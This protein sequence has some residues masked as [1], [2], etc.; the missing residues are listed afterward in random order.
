MLNKEIPKEKLEK[1]RLL[2]LDSDGVTI[3]RGTKISEKE[4]GNSYEV[5]FKTEV[6]SDELAKLIKKLKNKI[7]ICICSGRSLIYLQSMYS[8]IGQERIIL[9]AENGIMVMIDGKIYQLFM[10]E[11]EYFRKIAKIREEIKHLPIS[12]FEPKQF[13]LTIHSPTELKEVYDIVKKNDPIGEL[14]IMWNG[15]AFDIMPKYISKGEGLNF[16]CQ[17]LQIDREE[18]IAIGDRIN[19]KEL[20]EVAGI[21]VSADQSNLPAKYF[22]VGKV[23]PG[24]SLVEYLLS[25]L[26]KH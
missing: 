1:L 17:F 13:I 7:R 8:K 12:G 16:L 3:P 9:M 23:L 11:E 21:G 22:T 6:I 10:F 26:K 14:K 19:D 18:V 4:N 20:L 15:E 25:A 2:V 5:S 24:E